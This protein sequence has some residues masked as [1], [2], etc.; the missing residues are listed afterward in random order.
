MISAGDLQT[1]LESGQPTPNVRLL[2]DA[3]SRPNGLA[4]SPDF[5]KLYVSN[6][7]PLLPVIMVFEVS[8][9]GALLNGKTFY[10]ASAAF[11]C[12]AATAAVSAEAGTESSASTC[13]PAADQSVGVPDGLKVDINGNVLAS[14]P[15]G[16]LVLNPQGELIGRLLLPDKVSNVAFGGD[17]RLYIT[18]SDKVVRLRVRTKSAPRG[19]AVGKR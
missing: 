11:T 19:E 1:A 13:D 18:A 10:D 7:D 8:S 4:F 6:S 2:H 5:S 3:L 15:G 16:V 9:S 17:G 12:N 14:G